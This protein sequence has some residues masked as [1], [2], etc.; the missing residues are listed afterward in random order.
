[1][2][3]AVLRRAGR[4]LACSLVIGVALSPPTASA[5]DWTITPR[6]AG[7]EIYNDNILFAAFN[8]MADFITTLSPGIS[9]DGESAR[10]KGALHYSPTLYVYARTS[11]LDTVRQNLFANG[12]AILVPHLFF[13]DARGYASEI[14]TNPAL[15]LF[16]GLSPAAQNALGLGNRVFSTVPKTELTQ[17]TSFTASPYVARRFGDLGSAEL[18][19][20]VTN[21]NFSGG[22]PTIFTPTG[23]AAPSGSTLTNEGTASFLTGNR[24]GR[25][26]SRLTFDTEERSG[27]GVLNHA[28]HDIA[29]LDSAYAIDRRLAALATI[30]YENIRFQS[31]PPVHISDAVWAAGARLTPKP[32]SSIILRYGHQSGITGPYAEAH[33]AVTARTTLVAKYTEGLSTDIEAIENSLA[34]STLNP[35][36]QPINSLTGLPETI[37]NTLIGLQNAV[38]RSKHIEGQGFVNLDRDQFSINIYRFENR[39]VATSISGTGVSERATGGNASWVHALTPLLSARIG[40]GYAHLT[41]PSSLTPS[42]GLISGGV[43]ARYIFTPS[44][45]GW[46]GYYLTDRTSAD[47]LFRVVSN[48]VFVGLGKTF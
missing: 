39:V 9:I 42:L 37:G 32:D 41:F 30:G 1:M 46:M 4:A 36:G 11:S 6:L 43:F 8:P 13:L 23:F 34:L 22:Q 26:S 21:T 33:Y 25:L 16:S 27:S 38:F 2:G 10:L 29:L 3:N 14:P 48:S 31:L 20:T 45:S 17:A 5:G 24:F 44:F 12:T 40:F 7:Q 18:R 47:P 19:Y 15:S 28:S 35:Q